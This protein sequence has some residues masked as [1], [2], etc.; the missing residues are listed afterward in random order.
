MPTVIPFL[1]SNI[2][3]P[4]FKVTLDNEDCVLTV[5]WNISALR[6][7][8]NVYGADNRWIITVPLVSTPPARN[9]H[10]AAYD[11]FQNAVLIQISD[12]LTWPVPVG[13]PITKPGTVI[14]YTMEGFQPNTYNGRFRCLHI[15]NDFFTFPMPRDPGPLIV[16]GKANR[17]LNM[18][19][20][21]FER[22][23]LIYRNG[24]FEIN[25]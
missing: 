20:S 19:E 24:S 23:T 1:P 3:T 22:S 25:P 10:A 11:P 16:V 9:V 13:G 15:N 8:I 21:V 7:Y 18:I 2:T 6:Y 12:S 4:T 14:M 17:Y 5:T